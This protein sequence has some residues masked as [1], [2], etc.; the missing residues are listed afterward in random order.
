[1]ATVIRVIYRWRVAQGREDDFEAAWRSVTTEL[2]EK[3]PGAR[4]S[5]LC[6]AHD[7]VDGTT[8]YVGIA[9]WDSEGHWAAR[10]G[11]NDLDPAPRRTMA[12]V[13]E[14]VEFE[15]LDELHDETVQD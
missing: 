1:M 6:R 5:V 3:M 12:E 11:R 13:A 2:K 15:L 9:R 7:E 10:S 4:G 8:V 14:M